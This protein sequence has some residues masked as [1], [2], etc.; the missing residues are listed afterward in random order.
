MRTRKTLRIPATLL[1]VAVAAAS[2]Q[3]AAWGSSRV[4]RP[5]TATQVARLVAAAPSIQDLPS[6]V[7]PSLSAASNDTAFVGTPSLK[8]CFPKDAT[9]STLS[10]C[11]FGDPRGTRTMVLWGDSHAF[12]WF[13][14]VNAIAKRVHWRLV[15]LFKYGCPVA[16]VQVWNVVTN[17]PYPSCGA[18]RTNMIARINHLKPSLVLMSEGFAA[19]GASKHAITTTEWTSGL[20][21]TFARLSPKLK[22]VLIGNTIASGPIMYPSACLAAYPTDIQRCSVSASDAALAAERQSEQVAATA[23]G[24][25]YVSVIPWTCSTVCTDVIGN[26]IAYYSAGHLTATYANYLSG[27]LTGALKPSM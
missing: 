24:V 1:L 4:P 10:A 14:A 21:T 18:F 22:K 6:D 20:A 23:D 27:V 19:E 12:M 16:D 25:R 7:T 3:Q 11:V 2:F 26:M 13:P 8:R 5:G 17:A 9:F 15:A